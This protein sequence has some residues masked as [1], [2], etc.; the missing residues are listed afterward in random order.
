MAKP[1]DQDPTAQMRAL[2]Q[3]VEKMKRHTHPSV[4][5][6][7]PIISG[8]RSDVAGILEQLLAALAA[9]GQIDDQTT[10]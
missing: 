4:V 7:P 10:G 6:D 1:A 9:N 3:Q 5:N 2:A 8:P